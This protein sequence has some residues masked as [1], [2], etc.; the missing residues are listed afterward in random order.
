M[1]PVPCSGSLKN[2]FHVLVL[3]VAIPEARSRLNEPDSDK[4]FLIEPNSDCESVAE[5][6]QRLRRQEVNSE[7]QAGFESSI[8]VSR[9]I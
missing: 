1:L 6:V 3:S 8:A 7:E 5:R 9:Q 2:R 4:F